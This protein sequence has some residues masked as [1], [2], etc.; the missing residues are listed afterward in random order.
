MTSEMLVIYFLKMVLIL[1]DAGMQVEVKRQEA[2]QDRHLKV[3]A[4]PFSPHIIFYCNGNEIENFGDCPD[5]DNMTYDGTLWELLKMVKVARNVTFSILS[6]PDKT[7]GYCYSK[8]NCTGMIGMVNRREV[9]FALGIV[10][11]SLHKL[12][13]IT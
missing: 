8:N 6:P 3:A 2:L 12:S 1:A 5:K 11:V 9:D 10:F 4:L 7:W 13:Y